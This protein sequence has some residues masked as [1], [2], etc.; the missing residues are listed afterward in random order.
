MQTPEQFEQTLKQRYQH[1]QAMHPLPD[2]VRNAVL[3]QAAAKRRRSPVFN[4]RNV[5]LAL[6]CA[7]LT[8]L[9]Y[10]LVLSPAQTGPLYYQVVVSQSDG[11]GET[12]QHSLTEQK[13]ATPNQAEHYQQYLASNSH[14]E[15]FHHQTGLLRQHQQQ[16]SIT[17]C[18]DLLLTIDMPLLAQLDIPNQIQAKPEQPQWVEFV[19]NRQGQ[20]VAIL[21][22]DEAL[23]CPHS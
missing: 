22:T 20:L 14:S 23:V 12:Q 18:N 4:W 17:V 5:Q 16:W 7:A 13:P 11:F 6:S 10:L 2:K 1:D 19:Q 21:P 8:V 9:G 3:Q 15:A